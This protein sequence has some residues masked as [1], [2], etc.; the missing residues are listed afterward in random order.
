MKD[1]TKKIIVLAGLC[2]MFVFLVMFYLGFYKSNCPDAYIDEI[3]A[4]F[5]TT[6]ENEHQASELIGNYLSIGIDAEKEIALKK[7]AIMN[8]NDLEAWEYRPRGIAIDRGGNIYQHLK[9]P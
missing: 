4:S 9:C 2:V 7:I 1:S 8:R 3:L 6:V 5:N